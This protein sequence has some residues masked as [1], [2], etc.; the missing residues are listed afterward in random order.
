MKVSKEKVLTRINL[1]TGLFVFSFI[2]FFSFICPYL[3]DDWH[4]MFVWEYFDPTPGVKRVEGL[5][6]IIVSMSNYYR[7]SG[8]RVIPHFL[9]YLMIFLPKWVFSIINSV[10]FV[11][12]C[13]LLYKLS[14]C[15]IQNRKWWLFP[16]V[17]LFAFYYLPSFGDNVLWISG[18]TNYMWMAVLLLA[19][20]YWVMKRW[21]KA[22]LSE[23]ILV[24]PLIM[25]SSAS[26]EMT[27]GMLFIAVCLRFITT[28][29]FFQRLLVF[30]LSLIPGMCLVL[31]APG[32]SMRR[33]SIEKADA[34][35]VTGVLDYTF[36][37][38]EYLLERYFIPLIVILFAFFLTWNL[39]KNITDFLYRNT[40]FMI[41][42]SG[43]LA[44]S[45]IGFFSERPTFFG[46]AV[47]VP[48]FFG[49]VAN[50][51]GEL[52]NGETDLNRKVRAFL[53]AGICTAVVVITLYAVC[54]ESFLYLV[55]L[56]PILVVLLLSGKVEERLLDLSMNW[57]A[58]LPETEKLRKVGLA[59]FALILGIVF[60]LN[61][62]MY[63][64]WVDDYSKYFDKIALYI[65]E[66]KLEA[67]NQQNFFTQIYSDFVPVESS[68][69]K[70]DYLVEWVATYY[71]KDTADFVETHSER[72]P[73]ER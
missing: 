20:I 41:G 67:A 58:K 36:Q 31:L 4:F 63:I 12:L 43:V 42:L 22:S 16:M 37:Y 66:D 27:G 10:M 15:Y 19:G 56:V 14:G 6:D 18:S 62:I 50:V 61:T 21:E 57:R 13:V 32:N 1:I 53:R 49:A 33:A 5:S 69:C 55:L 60:G 34:P 30:I 59:G 47:L 48:G 25:L 29:K 11:M 44:L 39:R 23:F 51:C 71:G 65:Q 9:A 68:R 40:Y 46:I 3:S 2:L 7:L 54:K 35:N 45:V 28:H 72:R 64:S 8:G 24:L 70:R 38:S 17:C 73:S 26:N 52:Q